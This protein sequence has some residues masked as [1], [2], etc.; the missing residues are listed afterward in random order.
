MHDKHYYE[1]ELGK[2]SLRIS[3][4]AVN[5]DIDFEVLGKRIDEAQFA[6]DQQVWNDM[7]QYMPFA[8]GNLIRQTDLLNMVA[9]GTGEVHI[10]DP[11]VEY[12]HY[13][14][15]GIVYVDPVYKVGGF[16]SP[17]YGFWSR[18]DV[19]KIPSDRHLEYTKE[20]AVPHW[21][22]VAIRNHAQDW[23]KL[24]KDVIEG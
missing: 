5:I 12:A 2:Y 1:S 23:L 24:V 11:T 8:D 22:E 13:M 3:S 21:D 14:Y 15:E 19:T 18:K 9:A 17:D 10:Y 6:L 7:Q 4:R 20:E 16:F